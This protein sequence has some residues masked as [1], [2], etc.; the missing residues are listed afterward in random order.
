MDNELKAFLSSLTDQLSRLNNKVD[1]IE[2][3]MNSGF[4]VVDQNIASV[5]EDLTDVSKVQQTLL[6]DMSDLKKQTGNIEERTTRTDLQLENVIGPRLQ[7]IYEQNS[8]FVEKFEKLD[9]L[10]EK[11][12][13]MHDDVFAIKEVVTE[14]RADIVRLK[15]AK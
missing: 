13:K 12:D 7:L 2:Q 11:V 14:D 5:K 4:S 15:Q 9:A 8:S 3:N 1:E 10:E 6:G